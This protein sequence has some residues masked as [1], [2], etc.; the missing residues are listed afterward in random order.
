[1]DLLYPVIPDDP[2]DPDDD[3]DRYF[4]NVLTLFV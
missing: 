4:F 3:Y 1:M 2:E